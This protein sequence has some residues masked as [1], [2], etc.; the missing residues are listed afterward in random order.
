MSG[1]IPSQ[2]NGKSEMKKRWK[3]DKYET[4]KQQKIAE[5]IKLDKTDSVKT[6]S[7]EK[8]GRIFIFRT[9]SSVG[10]TACTLLSV[11][12]SKLISNLWYTNTPDF[13]LTELVSVKVYRYH[14]CVDYTRLAGPRDI[15]SCKIQIQIVNDSMG[16]NILERQNPIGYRLPKI[17]FPLGDVTN[18]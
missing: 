12:T 11:S 5:N 9:F 1:V 10:K 4:S 8:I 15:S 2:L 18:M 16:N 17:L 14:D 7:K 13:N 3:T 6:R